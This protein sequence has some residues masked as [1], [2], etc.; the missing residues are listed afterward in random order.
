MVTRAIVEEIVDKSHVRVRIPRTNKSSAAV[1]STPTSEL[2]I[3]TI[4]ST[5]GI[6]PRL[7]K[8]DAVF[9]SF[10]DDDIGMPVVMGL[11][12]NSEKTGTYS[13]TVLDS[14]K[15]NVDVELPQNTTIGSVSS[16]SLKNLQGLSSNIQL[17]IETNASEHKQMNEILNSL[18]S[19]SSSVSELSSQVEKI[20]D[21]L[22]SL[23]EQLISIDNI[24]NIQNNYI[25]E[26]QDTLS[27]PLVL[28]S[29]SYG[30]SAPST[31]R[32]PVEGQL[33]LYIQ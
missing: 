4:C 28:N 31:I 13:D 30:T 18:K 9:I 1:G 8:N 29:S 15:V 17:Q 19:N 14:L 25:Q 6:S 20:S 5:P 33:Y 2:A 22:Q 7:R 10:E 32:N 23:E 3:A 21:N 11:L 16:D 27:G 24:D 26:L 12:F